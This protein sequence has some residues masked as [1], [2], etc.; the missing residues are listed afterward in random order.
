MRTWAKEV[1][2][3]RDRT[4]RHYVNLPGLVVRALTKKPT[5]WCEVASLAEPYL[6]TDITDG[7]IGHITFLSVLG[8]REP[9]DYP[10]SPSRRSLVALFR[11]RDERLRVEKTSCIYQRGPSQTYNREQTADARAVRSSRRGPLTHQPT[12]ARESSSRCPDR[13]CGG[14]HPSRPSC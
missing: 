8:A 11:R 5:L 12:A 4:Y 10:G 3:T 2:T 7:S 9:R 6:S 1:G 13:T 14:S